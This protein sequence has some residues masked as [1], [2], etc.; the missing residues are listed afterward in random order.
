MQQEHS[1]YDGSHKWISKNKINYPG[2]S[3]SDLRLSLVLFFFKSFN[4]SVKLV[5]YIIPFCVKTSCF[6]TISKQKNIQILVN[7]HCAS[8]VPDTLLNY[9]N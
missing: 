6:P 4:V 1:C 2:F 8:I 5:A 7:K 9:F 3:I